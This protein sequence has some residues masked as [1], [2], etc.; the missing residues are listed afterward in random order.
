LI[1]P[2][3]QLERLTKVGLSFLG[4]MVRYSFFCIVAKP[5][6]LHQLNLLSDQTPADACEQE[7]HDALQYHR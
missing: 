4:E 6:Y 1:K 5:L 2:E 7:R 3:S